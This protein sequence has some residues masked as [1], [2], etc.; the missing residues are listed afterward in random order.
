MK[1]SEK[2]YDK[3]NGLGGRLDWEIFEPV[4]GCDA[5]LRRIRILRQGGVSII[6]SSVREDRC[7]CSFGFLTMTGW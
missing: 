5:V 1:N 3:R 7:S 4:I 2:C 6:T